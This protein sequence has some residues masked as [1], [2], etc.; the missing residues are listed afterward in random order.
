MTMQL[1][2]PLGAQSYCLDTR[3]LWPTI[4]GLTQRKFYW[5]KPYFPGTKEAPLWLGRAG[6]IFVGLV[7]VCLGIRYFLAGY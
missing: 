4:L 1:G 7:F 6:F 3:R 5:C 2:D